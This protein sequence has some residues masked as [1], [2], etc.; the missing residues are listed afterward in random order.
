MT[1]DCVHKDIRW[2]NEMTVN[3]MHMDDT[4]WN[5][6]KQPAHG[7]TPNTKHANEMIANSLHTEDTE[8]INEI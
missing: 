3:C 1:V 2:S 7:K 4:I 5:D 6:S 8:N